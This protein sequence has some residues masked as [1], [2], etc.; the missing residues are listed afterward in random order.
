MPQCNHNS[1]I[2]CPLCYEAIE[3]SKVNKSDTEKAKWE[4][5]E[6][7]YKEDHLLSLF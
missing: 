6:A 1:A 3:G 4:S 5:L 7:A 2:S